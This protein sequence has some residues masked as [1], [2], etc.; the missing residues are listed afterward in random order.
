MVVETVRM[1]SKGQLV[2]PQDIREAMLKARFLNLFRLFFHI[3]IRASEPEQREG[4]FP[5][6][7]IIID[8]PFKS[9]NGLFI[10]I[11]LKIR[12]FFGTLT[13]AFPLNFLAIS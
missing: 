10:L 11:A 1:S 9:R 5:G 12:F 7:R 13:I 6:I 4:H 2:I 3:V 8:K